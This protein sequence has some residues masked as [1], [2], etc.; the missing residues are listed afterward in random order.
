[1]KMRQNR[2]H[3]FILIRMGKF[4]IVSEKLFLFIYIIL[5][6]KNKKKI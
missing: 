6:M 4:Y 1:M 2:N 3:Q 5:Y